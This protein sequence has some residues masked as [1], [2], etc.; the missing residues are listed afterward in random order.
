M[1]SPLV[2][3]RI[4]ECAGTTTWR[5]RVDLVDVIAVPVVSRSAVAS[6]IARSISELPGRSPAFVLAGAAFEQM[7]RSR[8]RTHHTDNRHVSGVQTPLAVPAEPLEEAA[9]I[10]VDAAAGSAAGLATDQAPRALTQVVRRRLTLKHLPLIGPSLAATIRQFA[11]RGCEHGAAPNRLVLLGRD[12]SARAVAS[13][14][15]HGWPRCAPAAVARR[16]AGRYSRVR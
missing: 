15:A 3:T 7:V 16:S 6:N 12:P 14:V 11:D 9:E 1:P 13:A 10:A 8:L 2:R 4:Q 5:D